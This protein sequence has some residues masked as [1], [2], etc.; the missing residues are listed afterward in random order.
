MN[1]SPIAGADEN[2]NVVGSSPSNVDPE[3]RHSTPRT[4]R[5]GVS[6]LVMFEVVLFVL[7]AISVFLSW[8]MGRSEEM[9]S[10]TGKCVLM[11]T[12]N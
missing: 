8:W 2:V 1:T 9:E 11:S 3:N 12:R 7:C 4:R 10:R 6:P 5:R